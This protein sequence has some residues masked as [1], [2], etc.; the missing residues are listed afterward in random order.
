MLLN[1]L[2][3]KT[4]EGHPEREALTARGRRLTYA[5]LDQ[6]CNRLANA[7]AGLGFARHDRLAIYLD[8]SPE[9][10]IALYAA[11]KA[12]GTFVII[13]P[14]VQNRK[15]QF[16][17][18]D[19]QVS[20]L[21][22]SSANLRFDFQ[23]LSECPTVRNLILT[24]QPNNTGWGL[25]W[26]DL[27]DAHTPSRPDARAIDADLAALIYTSGSTGVPKGVML[28]HLNMLTAVRSIIAYLGNTPAD[29]ILDCLP[30][31]FDYGLYQV[32]MASAFGGRVILEKGFT[33]PY[34]V[35]EMIQDEGV[36]GLP[37]VPT[38]AVLLL[39]MGN[40]HQFDFS[41]LRYITN[42]AQALAPG[43]IRRM[44]Q[45]F[46]QTRLFSMYGLTECKRVAYLPP[47][48]ILR[49]P[50]SVGKAI[51]NTEVYLVDGEDRKLERP[52]E[53]GELVVRGSH[54]MRGYWNRPEETA[55]KLRP[56]LLPGEIVLY[57][58][59]LFKQDGEGFLYFLSR[60]DDVIKTAGEMVSPREV[61]TVISDL[62]DVLEVSVSGV[63][64][65]V[66]GNAV[67]AEVVL[68]PGSTLS[69]NDIRLHCGRYL[70]KFMIPRTILFR[71]SLPK[72]LT[73]K[74][75]KGS[76]AEEEEACAASA[77]NSM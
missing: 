30:L 5:Q 53:S 35:A 45:A 54:I 34:Q 31:S 24:D 22:S 33:Y 74:I 55:R 37:L 48:E 27:M 58:G 4:A 17:L 50:T 20:T 3:E 71:S 16:I 57:T 59:D 69:E 75:R 65:Q 29:V 12:G 40:L 70:E 51:P 38:M 25:S 68:R 39:E 56:G 6:D 19:C 2:L 72:T 1:H 7:L 73:G 41:R 42:T 21:V 23:W 44:A 26:A 32:L 15:L 46:P 14:Q 8:N 43:L 64:D 62:D 77:A 63:A 49:R 11:L 9:S 67:L 61:E 36:T 52:G 13:H 66:L 47:E 60:K 28:T 10:V 76:P 18:N